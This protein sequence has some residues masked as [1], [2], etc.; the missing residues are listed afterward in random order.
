MRVKEV[1]ISYEEKRSAGYQTV[2]HGL[3]ITVELAQGE[4]VNEAIAKYRDTLR[5]KVTAH[6]AEEANRLM[7][8]KEEAGFK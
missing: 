6:T 1:V 4:T 8:E 2:G 7:R 5:D 3:S